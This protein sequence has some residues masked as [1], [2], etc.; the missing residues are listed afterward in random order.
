MPSG[1][2]PATNCPSFRALAESKQDSKGRAPL[3]VGTGS[4]P[5]PP[6]IAGQTLLILL[7][8]LHLGSAAIERQDCVA[9]VNS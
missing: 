3:R 4:E 2:S 7:V 8:L 9:H 5:T 6:A 1:W